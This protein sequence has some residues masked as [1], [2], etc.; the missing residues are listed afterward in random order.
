MRQITKS[1]ILGIKRKSQE[2]NK[3]NTCLTSSATNNDSHNIEQPTTLR[4]TRPSI[5]GCLT[6][7][8]TPLSN[9]TNGCRSPR[10]VHIGKTIHGSTIEEGHVIQRDLLSAFEEESVPLRLQIRNNAIPDLNIPI[11]DEESISLRIPMPNPCIPDLNITIADE[12]HNFDTGTSSVH[13]NEEYYDFGDASN[14]CVHCGALFWFEERKKNYSSKGPTMFPLC[15]NNGKIKLQENA[16]PPKGIFELFFGNDELSKKFLQDIRTYNA[17]F[18]FTSMGGKIDKSLNKGGAPTV[19][20]LSGQNYHLMGGLL[21]EDGKEPH[22]AQLYIY[23]T[24]NEK[25]NRI[26]AVRGRVDQ[27]DIHVEIVNV[28]QKELDQNNVLVQSFRMARSELDSN[29][30]AEVKIKLLGKC[31]RDARTYNLPQ[32]SEVAAL[33]V[34]DLDTSIGDRD[35]VVQAKGGQLQRISELNPSYLPLQYPLLFLYGE[36]GYREDIA[37][38]NFVVDAYTIVESGRL[39][40]IRTHQKILRCESYS[41]LTDA[42]TRGEVNPAAQGRRIILPSSFIGGA[43]YMI[44]N[45]KDAM[46]IC[47]WIGYPDLFI[48]F[49]CN[50]KWPEV[51][52]FLKDRR[53]KAEDRPDI[54]CRLFK[55]KLDSLIADCRKNKLFGS[56]AGVI[57]TIEFQ[58]RGLPHAHMLLFLGKNQDVSDVVTLDKIISAEIP[59]EKTDV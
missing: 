54:I 59:D 26:K 57:Y 40:Y 48:T 28:I 25:N 7:N 53:L 12:T 50:P 3:E 1:T 51:Q 37:F 23:D 2:E 5:A 15:C 30:C 10:Q 22:F 33:I 24:A 45:Y 4:R 36:D 58:K 39:I 29:P 18:C 46:A 16:L 8:I 6:E 32:V 17:M 9:I 38:S 14:S 41:G 19:F 44:Q 31:T 35:I 27:D 47:R 49:T 56:V 52:R 42:L 21:P 43:R 13:A 55:M 20:R 11:D 34:G